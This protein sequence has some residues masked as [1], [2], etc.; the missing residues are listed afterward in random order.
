MYI[1]VIDEVQH[2]RVF[3][4]YAR[5]PS[6]TTASFFYRSAMLQSWN[7]FGFQDGMLEMRAQLPGAVDSASGNP[8]LTLG[9]STPVKAIKYYPT[10]PG[11][12]MMGNLGRAIFSASTNRVWPFSYSR[13]E[14]DLFDPSNQRISACDAD[15]G[16]VLNKNQ[17][18]GAPET[19]LLEGSGLEIS[20]S[21]Q[22]APGMPTGFCI[23]PPDPGLDG[24]RMFCIYTHDCKTVGAN[25]V[26]V[27]TAQYQTKRGHK[28][29]YQ[30]LRYGANRYCNV[31]ASSAQSYASV[32]ASLKR[33]VS[34]NNCMSEACSASQDVN[35][36]LGYMDGVGSARWASTRM[37]RAFRS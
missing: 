8:D 27:P 28:S 33:G 19:D 21:L 37:A 2:L 15:P 3:N 16:F 10:W 7:K 34:G 26:D 22:I 17:G 18:R 14:P 5:P 25:N 1:K 4:A 11:I 29:W 23:V 20:L 24:A 30:G 13:Y 6:F 32:E 36:D 31:N 12:W 9:K 35:A